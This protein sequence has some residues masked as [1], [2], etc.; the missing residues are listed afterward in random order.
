MPSKNFEPLVDVV[1]RMNVDGVNTA[2]ASEN[3][4]LLD[5]IAHA[6]ALLAGSYADDAEMLLTEN[7]RALP[8]PTPEP[9]EK[10]GIVYD[11]VVEATKQ[12]IREVTRPHSDKP[13]K[14]PEVRDG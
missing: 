1:V 12:A 13:P 2:L 8:D 4:R 14:P 5:V 3:R 9:S 7:L 10:K 6:H 11:A